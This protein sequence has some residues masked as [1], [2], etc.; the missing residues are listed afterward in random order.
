MT[1]AEVVA[2]AIECF[3]LGKF[4][5][6][7]ALCRQVVAV[8]PRHAEAL[9]V[10][11]LV[12]H[13]TGHHA[14]ALKHYDSAIAH[15]G[16][17]AQYHSS[18]G[19]AL[20][21]LKR[22]EEA[23]QSYRQAIEFNPGL[24][25]AHHGL[26]MLDYGL[27]DYAGAIWSFQAEIACAP[28]WFAGH[29]QLANA[30]FQMD[31]VEA[32]IDSYRRALALNPND[33]ATH[34]NLGLALQDLDLLDEAIEHCQRAVALQPDFPAAHNHLGLALLRNGDFE[35]GLA[36]HEWRWWVNDLR[37]GGHRF[38]RPPWRG[39]PLNGG[40]IL[41][42]AEQGI[43]DMLQFMRYA[44]LVAA[45][46]GHVL[47]EVPPELKQLAMS[48]KGVEQVV[49][50]GETLPEF[51]HHCAIM[52]LPLAFATTVTTIPAETAYLA[53]PAALQAEWRARL[54][55][56]ASPRVGLIW[57]G[58]PQH[59]RDRDRSIPLAALGLLAD[60]GATFYSLQKGPAAEQAKTPP[61]GM[62]LHEL[63]DALTDFADTAAAMGALDLVIS[64]DTSPAHLAGAIGRPLWL[65][66][67]HAPDW[68]WL[69]YR[70]DSPWYPTARL[71]RQ[72]KRGDWTPVIA[73][74]AAELRRLS[75]GDRS[76]LTPPKAAH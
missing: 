36:H 15:N 76:V 25:N 6:A 14:A 55:A 57:S 20:A 4:G 72:A 62:V 29:A 35:A 37:M 51:D 56:G 53:P 26:G 41:L 21:A 40:R 67:P 27:Q 5:E 66:L 42:H 18:R 46:G 11:G 17:I 19:R 10:L 44:P 49:T 45:R 16:A 52:S 63:G 47:I 75:A 70:E 8:Q 22:T 50:I 73:R 28:N 54:G 32:S 2:S 13:E 12:A 23:R 48:L 38:E 65:L 43:G 7:E 74:V 34:S 31:Q 33:A 71:F 59:R 24:A 30:L 64:V 9:H 60:T 3:R 39:E 68:R 61:A 1:A 58:R 69:R